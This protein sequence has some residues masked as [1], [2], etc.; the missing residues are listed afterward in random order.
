MLENIFGWKEF[1]FLQ[2]K[3]HILFQGNIITSIWYQK[4]MKGDF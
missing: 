4:Y 3:G 2:I 1:K